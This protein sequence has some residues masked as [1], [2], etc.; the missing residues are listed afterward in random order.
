MTTVVR[1]V[2]PY[3]GQYRIQEVKTIAGL[4]STVADCRESGV[5][6]SVDLATMFFS[7]RL[8]ADRKQVAMEVQH[9]LRSRYSS[10]PSRANVLCLFSGCGVFGLVI[11]KLCNVANVMMVEM[12]RA[13]HDMA[14]INIV[15]NNMNNFVT[16]Q[17][18]DAVLTCAELVYK[19]DVIVMTP[20]HDDVDYLHCIKHIIMPGVNS[21]LCEYHDRHYIDTVF[22]CSR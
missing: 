22:C 11:A 14:V 7:S 13:A 3:E 1:R 5:R 2:A 15:N 21:V 4:V 18:G 19:Y 17:H 9:H 6:I 8:A 10:R 20:P 12:N 16:A